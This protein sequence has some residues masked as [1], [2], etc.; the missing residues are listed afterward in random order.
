MK[1]SYSLKGA[2]QITDSIFNY[3]AFN[4]NMYY[5]QL[6][7]NNTNIIISVLNKIKCIQTKCKNPHLQ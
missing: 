2:I 5:Y 6:L 7:L 3:I 1:H 4:K